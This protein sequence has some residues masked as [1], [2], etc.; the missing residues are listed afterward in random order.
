MGTSVFRTEASCKHILES[1]G[2]VHRVG[3][4]GAC[5]RCGYRPMNQKIALNALSR[6][7]D[8]YIC[9]ACGMEEAMIAASR[10]PAIP[11]KDWALFQREQQ[12]DAPPCPVRDTFVNAVSDIRENRR[13]KDVYRLGLAMVLDCPDNDCRIFKNVFNMARELDGALDIIG[14]HPAT[15]LQSRLHERIRELWE[16]WESN[17]A[18]LAYRVQHSKE[19][20]L[21]S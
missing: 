12:L 17:H 15:V 5:P 9:E 3:Q 19:A 8:V 13:T 6:H 4:I 1:L 14:G 16:M 20:P 21:Q 2:E 18:V 7:A 11:L 10:Q